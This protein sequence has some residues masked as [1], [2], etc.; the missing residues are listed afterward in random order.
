MGL[1]VLYNSDNIL[2]TKGITGKLTL[3]MAPNKEIYEVIIYDNFCYFLPKTHLVG[4][5]W[6]W[7]KVI[8]MNTQKVT[9]WCSNKNTFLIDKVSGPM[10]DE[11]KINVTIPVQL[12]IL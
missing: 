9:F 10:L 3:I 12:T 7:F 1:F 8:S 5:H 4:T 2:Q 11:D 6:N